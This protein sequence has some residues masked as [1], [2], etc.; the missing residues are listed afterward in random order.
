[1]RC[2]NER[3]RHAFRQPAPFVAASNHRPPP[4]ANTDGGGGTGA[5]GWVHERSMSSGSAVYAKWQA[6]QVVVA[7]ADPDQS[8]PENATQTLPCHSPYQNVNQQ[9]PNN[10]EYGIEEERDTYTTYYVAGAYGVLRV[11]Q[12]SSRGRRA[13]EKGESSTMVSYRYGVVR[14]C[15][16]PWQAW[17]REGEAPSPRMSGAARVPGE[18]NVPAGR[19]G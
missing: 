12:G 15:P 18:G 8:V 5:W 6:R 17:N 19:T 7:G 14:Q 10:T 4:D 1:V 13:V 2:V 3:A 11:R 16:P 9:T